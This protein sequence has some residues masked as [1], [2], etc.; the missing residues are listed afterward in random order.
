MPS[1]VLSIDVVSNLEI[2]AEEV[3]RIVVSSEVVPSAVISAEVVV[4]TIVVSIIVVKPGVIVTE[5]GPADVNTG[6]DVTNIPFELEI[7]FVEV[8]LK[9]LLSTEVASIAVVSTE[10]LPSV[11]ISGSQYTFVVPAVDGIIVNIS[12]STPVELT[13]FVISAEVVPIEVLSTEMVPTLTVS[14]K[15]LVT[16]AISVVSAEV[17]LRVAFSTELVPSV[18]SAEVVV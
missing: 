13:E 14:A 18:D 4:G 9:V 8:V 17:V 10:E 5:V 7:V 1:I 2:S 6:V 16:I 3:H 11:V 15:V 12:N